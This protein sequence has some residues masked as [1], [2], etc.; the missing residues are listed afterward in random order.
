MGDLPV[1]PPAVVCDFTDDSAGLSSFRTG[2]DLNLWTTTRGGTPVAT[3]FRLP[4]TSEQCDG[5]CPPRATQWYSAPVASGTVMVRADFT[6][7][8][9]DG[10]SSWAVSAT[11]PVVTT[12]DQPGLP[13][14][15][16]AQ[17]I[18]V[19]GD[20]V[21]QLSVAIVT[22]RPTTS[23]V[24][25]TGLGESAPCLTDPGALTTVDDATLTTNR[26]VTV[27]GL[28]TGTTYLV[29]AT[30]TDAEGHSI[31]YSPDVGGDEYW[32]N[33]FVPVSPV[34]AAL[35]IAVH[36]GSVP[37]GARHVLVSDAHAVM[38]VGARG[39]AQQRLA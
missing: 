13:R 2:M 3:S 34:T 19:S 38:N 9:S 35:D 10:L 32:A 16:T 29:H 27:T 30:I 31:R 8:P 18:A 22:D 21:P 15:D 28:C 39:T 5:P 14:L 33:G 24:Q 4:E 12:H 20:L 23:S 11:E 17:V 26:T 37:A 6:E 36:V 1:A 25:V 7:G